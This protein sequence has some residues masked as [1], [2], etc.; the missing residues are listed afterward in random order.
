M[1][2][3]L[4]TYRVPNRL[5]EAQGLASDR[6]TPIFRDRDE[7]ASASD[8]SNTIKDALVASENLS[9][10]TRPTVTRVA[11]KSFRDGKPGEPIVVAELPVMIVP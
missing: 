6:L 7:L 3:A 2:K 11:V 4:E 9:P 5:V 8:L 1:H 10:S